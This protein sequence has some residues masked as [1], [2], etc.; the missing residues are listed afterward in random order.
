M[1]LEIGKKYRNRNGRI[2]KITKGV[3]PLIDNTGNNYR[4]GW[5]GIYW[6]DSV[7]R[8]KPKIVN[9]RHEFNGKHWDYWSFFSSIRTGNKDNSFNIPEKDLIEKV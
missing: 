9:E 4:D 6:G 1:K 2:L 3:E 7:D 8:K 5:N